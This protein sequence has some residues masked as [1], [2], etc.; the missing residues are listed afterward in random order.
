MTWWFLL[1]NNT[2][3]CTVYYMTCTLNAQREIFLKKLIHCKCAINIILY[4]L[5]FQIILGMVT[6]HWILNF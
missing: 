2:V 4:I 5:H 3:H 6:S 1:D